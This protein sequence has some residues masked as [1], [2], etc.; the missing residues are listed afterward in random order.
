MEIDHVSLQNLDLLEVEVAYLG[1]NLV[2]DVDRLCIPQ[3]DQLSVVFRSLLVSVLEAHASFGA[4]REA[5]QWAKAIIAQLHGML[6]NADDGTSAPTLPLDHYLQEMAYNVSAISGS[7]LASNV[8]ESSTSQISSTSK[9]WTS[10]ALGCLNLYVPNREFDPALRPFVERQ[11]FIANREAL[12]KKLGVL[13]RFGQSYTG[14][15][16]TLRT[17]QVRSELLELGTEPSVPEIARPEHSQL[18][19]LQGEF[20]A[21]LRLITP[22]LQS[23]PQSMNTGFV[24]D[25]LLQQ[26]ISRI[27]TRLAQYRAYE[28][29]TFP[30]IGF[31]QCL[32]IGMV[33]NGIAEAQFDQ[34]TH[35]IRQLARSTPLL[36]AVPAEFFT[37]EP[38]QRLISKDGS[39][40][41]KLHALSTI[42][43]ARALKSGQVLEP[44]QYSLVA[45]LFHQF[46]DHWKA[47]LQAGQSA[48]AA[49]SSTYR[50]RGGE[51]E[52]DE[53]ADAEFKELFPSD[54]NDNSN[55]VKS[56][57]EPYGIAARLA[58]VH[59]SIFAQDSKDAFDMVNRLFN[60]TAARIGSSA[61]SSPLAGSVVAI[62]ATLPLL[63]QTLAEH[64]GISRS[65]EAMGRTYNMYTD[66]NIGQA[67]KLVALVKKIQNRF[68][69]IHK[70]WPEHATIDDVLRTCDEILQG[71]HT[72]PVVTF[73]VKVEKLHGFMHGWQQV[74]SREYSAASL[75]DAVTDLIVS[76]RQLELSTWSRLLDL[77]DERCKEDAKAWWFIAYENIVAV[78][79]ELLET[80][81]KLEGHARELLKTLEAFFLSTGLGQFQQRLNLLKDFCRQVETCLTTQPEFHPIYQAL[82]NFTIYFS[83]FRGPVNEALTLGRQTLEKDI[84][85]AIQLASWRDRNVDAL[86]QS[87][88]ASHRKLFKLVGKYRALLG[89]S[90]TQILQGGI[91]TATTSSSYFRDGQD[92]ALVDTSQDSAALECCTNIVT[93]SERPTRFKNISTTVSIMRG[94]ASLDNRQFDATEELDSF[95][96]D[97][98]SSMVKLR[99]ATP[100]TSTKENQDSVKNLKAQKRKLFADTLRELRMMGLRSS[101]GMDV[102]SRQDSLSAVLSIL[103]PLDRELCG[104]GIDA[105][106]AFDQFLDA[107]V[108]ARQKTRDHSAD[109]TGAEVTRSITYLEDLLAIVINQRAVVQS[110]TSVSLNMR[111]IAITASH[112]WGTGD[113][114]KSL[115]HPSRFYP[116]EDMLACLPAIC[117]LGAKIVN[118]QTQLAEL[119]WID[120]YPL[121]RPTLKQVL[122]WTTSAGTEVEPTPIANGRPTFST[123][124]EGWTTRVFELL[125][126]IL[127]SM[128]DL[129]DT[130]TRLPQSRDDRAWLVQEHQ[131]LASAMSSAHAEQIWDKFKQLLDEIHNLDSPS[132]AAAL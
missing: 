92:T 103:P 116:L 132:T 77:E 24:A 10:F 57:R 93:W 104:N 23:D 1:Q 62:E 50:Y 91:P 29:I 67:R 111:D 82:Q 51:D 76:W 85:N 71:H 84:K 8:H 125:D 59:H 41:T 9:M 95:V 106:H 89:Q 47:Q 109:L 121:L 18:P 37:L 45:D 99:K 60:H 100:T 72:A 35:A 21:L 15:L 90:V 39:A 126:M 129:G 17:H 13:E 130:L 49:K 110:A 55:G 38:V 12:R 123:D 11:E 42:A 101:L 107:M 124:V 94:K 56:A 98:E 53:T 70:V 117:M 34:P 33:L 87:A 112:V 16:Q 75:Y 63:Y 65:A 3:L 27:M 58:D 61:A 96:A 131:V 122:V 119:E 83:H 88:K 19:Q 64:A 7:Y 25:P 31:L 36:G 73:L 68:R 127:G 78:P 46:Y 120:Q 102:L 5:R 43:V 108:A 30:A 81:Q 115:D 86:R 22:L 4:D 28:D 105:G 97:L 69:S 26:N 114:H 80:G 32:R 2:N 52:Q 20:S 74:A 44:M 113:V 14:Q 6:E 48:E 40:E 128:Q 66:P 118:S 79:L 54:D